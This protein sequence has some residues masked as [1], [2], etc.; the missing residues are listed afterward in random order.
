M[1]QK[2]NDTADKALEDYTLDTPKFSMAGETYLC[3]CVKVYDGDTITV[4]FKPKLDTTYWK[5]RIRM[6]GIDTYELRTRDVDEK[7]KAYA[8]RDFLRELTLDKLV[9]VKC[10]D[11]DDFGRILGVVYIGDININDL[12]IESGHAQFRAA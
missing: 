6:L 4:V 8:A 12:M 10:G 11:F 1:D 5:F 3:K 7:A 2:D 9:S